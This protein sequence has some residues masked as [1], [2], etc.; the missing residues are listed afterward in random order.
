MVRVYFLT[1][2]CPTCGNRTQVAGKEP[3][4]CLICR[5]TV[6][7]RCSEYF[8]LCKSCGGLLSR[9]EHER[10][11]E[12]HTIH[13]SSKVRGWATGCLCLGIP[14]IIIP[15]VMGEIVWEIIFMALIALPLVVLAIS[16]GKSFPTRTEEKFLL[17]RIVQRFLAQRAGIATQSSF[18][19]LSKCP[20]CHSELIRTRKY[21]KESG[22]PLSRCT[23]CGK[24]F[25]YIED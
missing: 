9:E 7:P 13:G 24:L 5:S 2:T 4:I 11:L 15:T 21:D 16:L 10:L 20:E 8:G 22:Q 25:Q 18:T 19:P 14:V 6:C 1:Y 17:Q 23:R 12:L 3:W